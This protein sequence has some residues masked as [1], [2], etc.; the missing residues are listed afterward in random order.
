MG[1]LSP[2]LQRVF[3]ELSTDLSLRKVEGVGSPG[4]A[5]IREG[6]LHSQVVTALNERNFHID[7][8]YQ[9]V[10]YGS[11]VTSD[12][13]EVARAAVAFHLERISIS[14]I[15]AR[16]VWLKPDQQATSHK[17]G[18]EFFVTERWQ[19]LERW[20]VLDKPSHLDGLLPLVLEAAGFPPSRVQTE[21]PHLAV[22]AALAPHPIQMQREVAR[23]RYLGHLP[24]TPHGEVE[25]FYEDDIVGDG[26]ATPPTAAKSAGPAKGT[27][28]LSRLTASS[29]HG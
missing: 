19:D 11:G 16:F 15:A 4:W 9:G 17:R 22:V 8:W 7:F 3:D 28:V 21:L 25:N 20:L 27:T 13:R 24:S 29:V 10:L 5:F 1:G 6:S 26:Q 2:P 23:H 14:E 12:L 18:A